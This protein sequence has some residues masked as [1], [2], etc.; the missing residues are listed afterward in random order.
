MVSTDQERMCTVM[1]VP[2]HC[3]GVV[4]ENLLALSCYLMIYSWC[5]SPQSLQFAL[6]PVR[7]MFLHCLICSDEFPF[8]QDTNLI[9][10]ILVLICQS[11]LQVSSLKVTDLIIGVLSIFAI[12]EIVI[13]AVLVRL[14]KKGAHSIQD[15]VAWAI[16]V[17]NPDSTDTASHELLQ[18]RL[19]AKHKK[20][21]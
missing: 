18:E 2:G 3:L 16:D 9:H 4:L 13:P 17:C 14:A 7:T 1:I 10:L 15:G 5:A 6:A 11:M 20:K 21:N 8:V 19:G 12:W